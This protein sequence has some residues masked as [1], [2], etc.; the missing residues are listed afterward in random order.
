MTL[1]HHKLDAIDVA[2]LSI[3]DVRNG[4]QNLIAFRDQL[5]TETYE[6]QED[7][8]AIKAFE[9]P[10]QAQL[11]LAQ[12][13]T[14]DLKA[15]LKFIETEKEKTTKPIN[16]LLKKIHDL[17]RPVL[18]SL[19]SGE[20]ELKTKM[21]AALRS[22][23]EEQT[24]A[25]QAVSA[26]TKAGDMGAARE[27]LTAM[28]EAAMPENMSVREI[29]KFRVK[30]AAKIPDNFL[31]VVVNAGAVKAAIDAGERNIHGLEIYREDSVTI[32]QVNK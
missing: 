9:I 20:K 27:A 14:A 30:D 7:L 22:F 4:L 24:K 1:T 6:A 21:A 8:K 10:D 28:P 11:D 3:D 25:L 5:V 19:E 2:I 13:V 23:V 12:T 18:T 15:K 16:A 26:A 29:W 17:Y 31:M 32:R